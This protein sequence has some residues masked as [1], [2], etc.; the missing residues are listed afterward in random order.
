SENRILKGFYKARMFKPGK[1]DEDP[2]SG[3]CDS[4][5]VNEKI[6]ITKLLRNPVL[7]SGANQM[8]GDTIHLLSD[9]LTDKLDTLKVFNN[10]FLIQ[11]DSLGFNQVKGER[12]TGL[13]TD[14]EMDTVNIDKNAQ[15]LYY[16]RNDKEELVGINNTFSSSI[17]MYL[18]DQQIT[19]VRFN[20]KVP[21]K[22]NPP[23]MFP[24]NARLLTGFNWRGEE[25]LHSVEDLFK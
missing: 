25:R 17:Q 7:W 1:L 3:K 24:E 22:L 2:M 11:K 9:T 6:G 16:F 4:I 10:A 8:T 12:L 20:K 14:N 15:V 18:K 19:G 13:F 23:S 5:Y 21:G